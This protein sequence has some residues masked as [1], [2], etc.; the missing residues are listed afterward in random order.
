MANPSSKQSPVNGG[1]RKTR[2]AVSKVL[3]TVI[4]EENYEVG[5]ELK[6]YPTRKEMIVGI[7]QWNRKRHYRED[8]DEDYCGLCMFTGDLETKKIDDDEFEIFGTMFLNGEDV[9][10]GIISHESLHMTLEYDRAVM[11]YSG[12][13][14]GGARL[15]NDP[16]ERI[17]YRLEDYVVQIHKFFEKHKIS[18]P[19]YVEP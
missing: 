10:T 16:E 18:I 19:I 11:K 14:S 3:E 15:G 2:K 9:D 17:A 8:S 13:Y 6:F 12:V 5:F 4:C 7:D 1:V